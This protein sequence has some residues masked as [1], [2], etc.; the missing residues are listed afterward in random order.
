MINLWPGRQVHK[1]YLGAIAGAVGIAIREPE[2][3]G[4]NKVQI[5]EGGVRTVAD[6]VG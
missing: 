1:N 3:G 4:I 6:I 2:G 5:A